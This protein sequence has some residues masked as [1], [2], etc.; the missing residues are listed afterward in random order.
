MGWDL[1]AMYNLDEKDLAEYL[2]RHRPGLDMEDTIEN[3]EVAA[4]YMALRCPDLASENWLIA[5]SRS[6]PGLSCSYSTSFIRDDPRL[7]DRLLIDRL[8]A[9]SGL[10]YPSVLEAMNFLI[11]TDEHALVAARGIKDF[12]PDD[13]RLMQFADWLTGTA[14]H[15]R[16]YRI[17]I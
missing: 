7:D 11:E 1:I 3:M 6:S 8:E 5:G 10:Q 9:E 13:T 14:S 16:E 15:C 2:A 4:S 12:Y 17:S